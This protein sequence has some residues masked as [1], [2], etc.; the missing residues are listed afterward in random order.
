[1]PDDEVRELVDASYDAAV[2]ALPKSRR[3]TG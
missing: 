3:P 2:A 1:V